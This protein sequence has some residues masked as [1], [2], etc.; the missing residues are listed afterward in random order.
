MGADADEKPR[1][2]VLGDEFFMDKYEVTQQDFER[3]MGSNPS[4]FKGGNRPVEKMTWNEVRDY[5]RKV[6]KRM[7]KEM[8]WEKGGKDTFYTWGDRFEVGHGNFCDTNC[9]KGLKRSKF[10]DGY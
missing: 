4:H 7:P 5:C 2:R 1:H 10:N 3:V 8:E 9:N 6:G